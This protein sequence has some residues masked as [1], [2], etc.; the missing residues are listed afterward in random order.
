M[1]F[2]VPL[3]HAHLPASCLALWLHHRFGLNQCPAFVLFRVRGWAPSRVTWFSYTVF[4]LELVYFFVCLVVIIIQTHQ[5]CFNLNSN[6]NGRQP[7][8]PGAYLAASLVASV[9][10]G[11]IPGSGVPMLLP[12]R[13][14]PSCSRVHSRG[15]GGASS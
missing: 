11:C 10:P 14:V 4:P 9:G 12:P 2:Y 6:L 7:R 15:G 3:L 8:A 1:A 5:V 13:L